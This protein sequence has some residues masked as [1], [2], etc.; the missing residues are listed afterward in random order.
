MEVITTS[1]RRDARSIGAQVREA[2]VRQ[3]RPAAECSEMVARVA[4]KAAFDA[5]LEHAV[6]VL[7]KQQK[8]MRR[9]DGASLEDGTLLE[10]PQLGVRYAQIATQQRTDAAKD[11]AL[12]ETHREQA[13]LAREQAE[14]GAVEVASASVQAMLLAQKAL[15][16][17]SASRS[18]L[19]GASEGA[20]ETETKSVDLDAAD[21]ALRRLLAER[22]ERP[23]AS[24]ALEVAS[25][26]GELSRR[27]MER[28]RARCL[29]AEA[30]QAEGV[31]S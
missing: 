19:L 9:E 5:A 4:S 28:S 18:S 26:C 6:G 24:H 22:P 30:A 11:S 23:R 12:L 16:A 27:L 13:A 15:K 14:Q 17:I 10:T 3:T 2:I 21:E 8:R 29:E 1:S 25:S 20:A 7:E 31:V